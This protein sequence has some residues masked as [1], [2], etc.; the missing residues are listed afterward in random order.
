MGIRVKVDTGAYSSTIH[1]H[2]IREY[3][4]DEG[5]PTLSFVLLDPSH[6]EY[7]GHTYTSVSFRQKPVRSSNGTR[8]VRYLIK[9]KIRLFGRD[10][11][12]ELSLSERGEMR[13]PVLLGRRLLKGR[14]LVDPQLSDLSVLHAAQAVSNT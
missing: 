5:R 13:Y 10:Y 9:T 12:V 1:C 4:D 6:P 11:P 7:D 2:H 14:F 8:E 3:V